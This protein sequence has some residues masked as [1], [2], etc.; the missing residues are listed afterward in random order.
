VVGV[1]VILLVTAAVVLELALP[2]LVRSETA[3]ARIQQMA[4][5]ATGREIHYAELDFGLVPPRLVMRAPELRGESADSPPAFEADG[6]ELEIALAPLVVRTLVVDSLVVQGATVRLIRTSDGI[7]LP[8]GSRVPAFS[9][10]ASTAPS[11]GAG[12]EIGGER[13]PAPATGEGPRADGGGGFRFAVRRIALRDSRLLLEDRTVSPPAAW[14]L[15]EVVATASGK[16]TDAPVD[17]EIQGAMASGGSLQ[18]KGEAKIGGPYRIEFRLQDVSLAPVAPYL[19]ADQRVGG[20]VTGTVATSREEAAAER[21]AVDVVLQGGDLAAENLAIQGR[22]KLRADLEGGFDD[23]SGSYQLDAT[24]AKVEY[25]VGFGKLRGTKATATGRIVTG[26]D[27][28]IEFEETQVEVE[29]AELEVQL[30]MGART[31]ATSGGAIDGA[32]AGRSAADPS[33]RRRGAVS[34]RSRERVSDAFRS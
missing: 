4:L 3:R 1:L 15:G 6:V 27:G 25:G 8:R 5:E 28:E 29:D 13:A 31:R 34:G 16:S 24:D 17:F 11:Q 12:S 22:M 30:E 33:S 18:A 7:E 14:E 21:V 32:I 19:D 26:E 2:R 20:S 10:G 9:A 23:V